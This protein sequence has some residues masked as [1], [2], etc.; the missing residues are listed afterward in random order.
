LVM[1]EIVPAYSQLADAGSR[2]RRASRSSRV[3]T[4][5][6]SAPRQPSASLETSIRCIIATNSPVRPAAAALESVEPRLRDLLAASTPQEA[7]DDGDPR[8]PHG[9]ETC[10]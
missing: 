7:A 1:L 5:R 10:I 8:V 6:E 4:T 3:N 2:P 9:P